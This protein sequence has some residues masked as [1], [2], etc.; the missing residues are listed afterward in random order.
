MHVIS[1]C[2]VHVNF[3]HLSCTNPTTSKSSSE[4]KKNNIYFILAGCYDLGLQKKE[5]VTK[6]CHKFQGF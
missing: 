2:I 5:L 6:R 1:V 3:G 4:K